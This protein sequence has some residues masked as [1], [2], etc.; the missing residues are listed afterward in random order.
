MLIV[1]FLLLGD[2]ILLSCYL[3]ELARTKIIIARPVFYAE[4][5]VRKSENFGL[6]IL[7]NI[8]II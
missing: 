5:S 3:D 8:G 2:L 4:E 6:R 7:A 1:Y